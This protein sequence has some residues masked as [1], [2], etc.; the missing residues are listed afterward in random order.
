[1]KVK[2]K[3][4]S[5]TK[6]KIVPV[7]VKL[8][9]SPD[10]EDLQHHLTPVGVCM[11]STKD[12]TVVSKWE[13]PSPHLDTSDNVIT[14]GDG[15]MKSIDTSGLVVFAMALKCHYLPSGSHSLLVQATGVA[16]REQLTKNRNP[17]VDLFELSPADSTST[18]THNR[19]FKLVL[20]VQPE[21]SDR[22][23]VVDQGI[24]TYTY[25]QISHE[26]TGMRFPGEGTD[27]N[28]DAP[29]F[30]FDT[31]IQRVTV[32]TSWIAGKPYPSWLTAPRNIRL[33]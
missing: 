13:F 10:V 18:P 7:E 9:Y 32:S 21:D 26:F 8:C 5:Q 3:K 1:M 22:G 12:N 14:L 15:E 29:F 23:A 4:N 6:M 24:K 11:H 27:S 19:I 31:E 17:E 25:G 20:F 16:S 28:P 2:K 33:V 30:H